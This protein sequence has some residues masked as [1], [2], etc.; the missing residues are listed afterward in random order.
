MKLL[1]PSVLCLV[2]A[3]EP[4]EGTQELQEEN[5][6]KMLSHRKQPEQPTVCLTD[7]TVTE[8]LFSVSVPVAENE[9][10]VFVPEGK[11]MNE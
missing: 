1:F 5:L 8:L 2:E 7:Q 10:G 3:V 9:A 6:G 11:K 4:V